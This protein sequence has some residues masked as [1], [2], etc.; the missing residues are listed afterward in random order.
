MGFLEQGEEDDDDDDDDDEEDGSGAGGGDN[1]AD[2]GATTAGN[3]NGD[4]V[5]GGAARI[6]FLYTLVPGAAKR[7]YG[8][9]VARLAGLEPSVLQRA[10]EKSLEMERAIAQKADTH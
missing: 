4:D 6:T 1:N 2:E 7:S 9:N 3:S 10:G 5:A 8:L